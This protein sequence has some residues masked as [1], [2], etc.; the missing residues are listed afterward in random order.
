MRDAEAATAFLEEAERLAP[1][2]DLAIHTYG[3]RADMACLAGRY[4][5]AIEWCERGVELIRGI[6]GDATTVRVGLHGP[7]RCGSCR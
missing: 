6:R 7:R 5:E 2:A 4:D 3:I 1:T